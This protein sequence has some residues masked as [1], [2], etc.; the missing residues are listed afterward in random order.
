MYRY[1][2]SAWKAIYKEKTGNI[3]ERVMSWRRG[4]TVVRLERPSRIDKARRLGYKSKQGIIVLRVRTGRG[5]MRRR[6]PTSGRR[7]KHLG[8]VRIKFAVSARE[9]AERRAGEK[10]PNL[11]VLNSYFLY[12]DGKYSWHEVILV[13]PH[14][15]AIKTDKDLSWISAK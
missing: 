9:V 13:D 6:R 12:R 11:K 2:G 3:R 10:F 7:P 14:H 1:V 5:G 15:P 4:P 8:V